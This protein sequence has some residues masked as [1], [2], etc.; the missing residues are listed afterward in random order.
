MK[1]L[2]LVLSLFTSA[3]SLQAP[4]AVDG[5]WRSD[6][7]NYWT[8][9]SGERWVSLQLERRAGERTGLSV[10]AQD[11]PALVDERAS[12]PVRFTIA[13]DAGTF[14]FDGRM[15]GGHGTGT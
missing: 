13:R 2:L 12:G 10:P 3:F 8:R 4:T 6:S 7:H 15:D 11:V 5:T 9:D 1:L 14:A